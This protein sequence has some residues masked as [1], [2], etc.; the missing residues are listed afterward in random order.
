MGI[1]RYS[2][3][4]VKLELNEIQL[5]GTNHG[6]GAHTLRALTECGARITDLQ[7]AVSLAR[8][9]CLVFNEAVEVLRLKRSWKASVHQRADMS[10]DNMETALPASSSDSSQSRPLLLS[11]QRRLFKISLTRDKLARISAMIMKLKTVAMAISGAFSQTHNTS[12]QNEYLLRHTGSTSAECPGRVFLV[13]SLCIV[14]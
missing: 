5:G 2:F 8:E 10:N 4:Y 12:F 11:G 3:S 6:Q 1:Y 9:N 13:N 7:S 14:H